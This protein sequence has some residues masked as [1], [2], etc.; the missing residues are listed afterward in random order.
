MLTPSDIGRRLRAGLK[1]G[2][3]LVLAAGA[4]LVAGAAG[5]ARA[6]SLLHEVQFGILYHDAPDLWSGFRME[7]EGID[8]NVEALLAP[9][10]P[11]LYGSIHPAFG[12]SISTRGDT[13]HA[14]LGARWRLELPGGVFL[15][16][17]L[18]AAVHDGHV[19]PDSWTHKALGSRV[20]FHIPFEA[21]LRLDA[22]N[23]FSFY[24]EHTSN[25]GL[26]NFNEGMDRMGVRYGYRF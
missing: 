21:G 20:L 8:I 10:L 11:F 26:A 6:Q 14:Y 9:S 5:Q 23:S 17:G 1:Y 3:T 7:R 24:F 15:G 19:D 25:A 18:G 13:S 4:M 12:A 2:L 16:V 22:H